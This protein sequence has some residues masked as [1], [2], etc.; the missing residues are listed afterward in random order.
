M[1]DAT[2]EGPTPF[3]LAQRAAFE[4][5]Y[6]DWHTARAALGNP[7]MPGDDASGNARQRELD[8]VE[9]AFLTTPAPLPWG[10]FMKWEVLDYLVTTEAESGAHADHRVIVGLAAIK[11]DVLRFGL[12]DSE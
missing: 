3:E 5:L 11:A 10:V 12:K 1:S 6:C 9:R 7:D 8:E 4:R 2:T